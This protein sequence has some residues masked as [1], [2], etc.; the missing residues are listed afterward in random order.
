MRI[1][2]LIVAMAI[3]TAPM[4][5]QSG[6]QGPDTSRTRHFDEL[7]PRTRTFSTI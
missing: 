7:G 1:L 4:L 2:F 6:P 3:L 5:A